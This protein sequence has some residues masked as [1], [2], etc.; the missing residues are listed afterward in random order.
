[1]N[2]QQLLDDIQLHCQK[3]NIHPS[4][5]LIAVS[6]YVNSEAVQKLHDEGQMTFGENKVQDLQTKQEALQDAKI[7]WHFIGT[8]QKNKINKLIDLNPMLLQSL[9]SLELALQLQQRLE[10]KNSRINALLQINS[11]NETSKSGVS[12]EESLA[13]YDQIRQ[14]CPNIHLKGVMGIG[15]HS[16]DKRVIIQSFEDIYKTFSK[17][18]DAQFCSM[19][20]SSDYQLAI[21]CGSN[22]LRI[23][24]LCFKR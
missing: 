22:M 12:A 24:S 8:L 10:A 14:T 19:G 7:N 5:D 2:Y 18:A 6:K 4:V 15:A 3:A 23:G 17:I 11:A 16:D 21:A 9:S 20:M 13:I 1:M